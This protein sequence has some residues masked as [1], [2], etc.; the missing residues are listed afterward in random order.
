MSFTVHITVHQIPCCCECGW[1]VPH[2]IQNIALGG[3][4]NLQCTHKRSCCGRDWGDPHF[5]QK[6]AS[7]RM[8]GSLQET[9]NPEL[10]IIPTNNTNS[11]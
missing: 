1:R 5:A 4:W 8:R 2:L 11:G 10:D 6:L 9:H 3:S 7:G